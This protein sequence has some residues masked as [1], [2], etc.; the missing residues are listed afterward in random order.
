MK[1]IISSSEIAK[2]EKLRLEGKRIV[3]VGGCFD[4]LHRGHEVFLEQ[5]KQQGD[6]LV[7]A[8]E[9]DETVT[10][11]KGEGRPINSQQRRAENLLAL[12]AVDVVLLLSLLKTNDEYFS[13]VTKIHPHVIAITEGDPKKDIKYTQAT[14]LGATL[15]TIPLLPNYSTT[16]L[17]ERSQ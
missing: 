2:I 9:S 6:I 11:L 5:A 14:S 15:F 8:L 12:P 7:V 3:L 13:L 1:A 10:Y 17:L 4:L 16:K